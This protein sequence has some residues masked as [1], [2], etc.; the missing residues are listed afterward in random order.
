VFRL[1]RYTLH[2]ILLTVHG[3][4]TTLEEQTVAIHT[5]RFT[6][7]I[8]SDYC[9]TGFRLSMANQKCSQIQ[10]QSSQFAKNSHQT[11]MLIL[12]T[13]LNDKPCSTIYTVQ[14]NFQEENICG[15]CNYAVNHKQVMYL[16]VRTITLM[17]RYT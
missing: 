7:T 12:M 2:G 11:Q 15:F 10:F 17:C 16:F 6:P 1:Y 4:L 3:T 5:F 8:V 9:A 14:Q 13:A